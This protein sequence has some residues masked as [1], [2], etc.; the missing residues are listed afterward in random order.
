MVFMLDNRDIITDFINSKILNAAKTF[1]FA[2]SLDLY[3]EKKTKMTA[4]I[5]LS[6]SLLALK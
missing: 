5:K 4:K 3:K 1:Q 6:K 2:A